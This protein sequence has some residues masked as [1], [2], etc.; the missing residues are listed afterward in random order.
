MGK[1]WRPGCAVLVE[2]VKEVAKVGR[3]HRRV[4]IPCLLLAEPDVE[5]ELDVTEQ[6]GRGKGPTHAGDPRILLLGVGA[7]EDMEGL[8]ESVVGAQHGQQKQAECLELASGLTERQTHIDFGNSAE[9]PEVREG[10]GGTA[11]HE[12]V[13]LV[14]S[15]VSFTGKASTIGIARVRNNEV[16]GLDALGKVIAVIA[17]KI[18]GNQALG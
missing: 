1:V 18:E 3:G 9:F 15:S 10:L 16:E 8:V 11:Q 6:R 7:Q 5:L 4:V 12:L 14:A 2:L 17:C 13:I